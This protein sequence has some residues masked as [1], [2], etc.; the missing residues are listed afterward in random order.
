MNFYKYVKSGESVENLRNFKI[1]FKNF[2]KKKANTSE[3]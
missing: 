1:N 3:F 2:W